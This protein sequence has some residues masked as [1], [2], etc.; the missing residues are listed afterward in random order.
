MLGGEKPAK[1][2]H[3]ISNPSMLKYITNRIKEVQNDEV[4]SKSL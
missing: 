2:F 4:I 1:L 3:T